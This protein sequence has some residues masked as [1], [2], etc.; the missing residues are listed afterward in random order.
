MLPIYWMM[1][2]LPSTREGAR[3]L[4]LVTIEQF[5]AMLVGVIEEGSRGNRI[6]E[7]P[8]IRRG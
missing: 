2:R 8:E 6:V 7:V 1:E 3:R 4:G 5:V